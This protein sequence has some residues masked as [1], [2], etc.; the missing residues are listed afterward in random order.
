MINILFVCMGN[1]CRSPSAEGFF[2]HALKRSGIEQE[3]SIDSAGTHNYHVG[4]APDP[5][6]IHA[7]AKFGVNI[8]HLRARSVSLSDFHHYDMI[9]AMDRNNFT[10][11]KDIQPPGSKA[12]LSKMM[13]YHPDGLPADVPDPYYGGTEGFASMCEL[14]E[15]A[16]EGLLRHVQERLN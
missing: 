13:D 5:R 16:A 14:L 7:T 9:I 4:Q 12:H 2:T 1:I 8:G 3:V 6:A 11:L 15:A 10:D